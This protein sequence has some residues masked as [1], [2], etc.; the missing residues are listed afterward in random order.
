MEASHFRL[1]VGLPKTKGLAMGAGT[2]GDDVVP[3][4]VEGG[5]NEMVSEF[6]YWDPVCVMMERSL[7]R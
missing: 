4:S 1:T 3:M 5:E 6:T 7:L 2:D